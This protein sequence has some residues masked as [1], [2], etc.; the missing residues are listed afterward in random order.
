MSFLATRKKEVFMSWFR[1]VFSARFW[2]A[3][4]IVILFVGLLPLPPAAEL[5]I[6]VAFLAHCLWFIRHRLRQAAR[7]RALA[8]A[9]KAEEAGFAGNAAGGSPNM[10]LRRQPLVAS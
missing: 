6:L 3:I 2:V 4:W 5:L 9:E 1:F 8:R 10:R 7:L